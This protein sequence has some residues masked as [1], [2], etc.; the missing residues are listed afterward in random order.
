MAI[1]PIDWYVL[2]GRGKATIAIPCLD[3]LWRSEELMEC[4][5]L[6]RGIKTGEYVTGAKNRNS[7]GRI[8]RGK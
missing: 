8:N 5:G 7:V 4:R 6:G 1:V 3:A 2:I